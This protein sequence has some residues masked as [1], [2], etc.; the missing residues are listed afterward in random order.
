MNFQTARFAPGNDL[1]YELFLPTY[2]AAAWYHKKLQGDLAK[3]LPSTLRQ[4]EDFVMHDYRPGFEVRAF[5]GRFDYRLQVRPPSFLI[6]HKKAVII[7][8]DAMHFPISIPF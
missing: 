2:T 8:C 4:V 3:D 7:N 1:P 5:S 6:K